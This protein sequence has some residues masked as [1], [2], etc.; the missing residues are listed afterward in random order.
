M[1][2][3]NKCEIISTTTICHEFYQAYLSTQPPKELPNNPNPQYPLV[4]YTIQGSIL[5]H[6]HF[7]GAMVQS[8]H[9]VNPKEDPK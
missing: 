4:A 3:S 7:L 6:N 1:V 9:C 8:C 5:M 2:K